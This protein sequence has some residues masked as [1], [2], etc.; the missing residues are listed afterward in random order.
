MVGGFMNG[1]KLE[2]I[3]KE[4]VVALIE[5]VSQP[6]PGGTEVNHGKRQ[7]GS[8]CLIPD[9]NQ[10]PLEYMWASLVGYSLLRS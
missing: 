9:P 3:W 6:L 1:D 5:V 2:R 4:A 8:K 10:E 7:S